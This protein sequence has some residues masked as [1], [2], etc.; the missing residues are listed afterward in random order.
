MLF[1]SLFFSLSLSLFISLFYPSLR[2]LFISL[3]LTHSLCVSFSMCLFLFLQVFVFSISL[4]FF[5]LPNSHLA[6]SLFFLSVSFVCVCVIITIVGC[7][8]FC[9]FFYFTHIWFFNLFLS[10]RFP[11]YII[12]LSFF[13]LYIFV[14]LFFFFFN[15]RCPSFC[16][17]EQK[18]LKPIILDSKK[19]RN[20]F[21]ESKGS[22][23]E[24]EKKWTNDSELLFFLN[25]YKDCAKA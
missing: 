1:I 23:M 19:K 17:R 12:L 11:L 8:Y 13:S 14:F 10:H 3:S 25:F 6:V 4:S 20:H 22:K 5:S 21:S 7:L 9:T 24:I 16:L 18:I 2:S 15:Y